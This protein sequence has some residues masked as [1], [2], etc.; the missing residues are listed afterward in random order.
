ML[1]ASAVYWLGHTACLWAALSALG[2][3]LSPPELV[4]AFATGQV[5]MLLPLPLGGAGSVDAAMTYALTLVGVALAPALVAVAA[6]RLFAFWLPTIPALA[7]L[8][9]L[10]GVGRAL[11]QAAQ[12]RP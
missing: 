8:A 6:Y 4:L 12:A 10:P 2:I 3:D 1:L 9:L 5:V 7:A 11:A